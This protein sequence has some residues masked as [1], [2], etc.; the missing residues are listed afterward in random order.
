MLKPIDRAV[1]SNQVFEQLRNEIL[2]RHYMPGENLPPERELCEILN[3]NRSSVREA[4]KRLEQARL[5]E[6]RQGGGIKV[7]DFNLHAGFDLLPWLVMPG[8]KI[9]F[10]AIRSIL[11]F[12]MIINPQIARYAAM[13][14]QKPELEQIEKIVDEIDGCDEDQV[15]RF[16]ELDFLFHYTMARSSENLT[17][18]LLYNSIK[19]IYLQARI[20]FT[21]MY[22]ETIRQRAGYRKVYE[23]LCAHDADQAFAACYELNDL[24][25][26]IFCEFLEMAQEQAKAQGEGQT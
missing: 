1:L 12:K 14:I 9:D 15:D 20:Y 22:K 2:Q 16:Q 6:I 11:E 3:V 8:G 10:I 5:I 26:R 23:G 21:E 7:L 19:D 24:G 17:F 4:L 13:R 18:I 25:N